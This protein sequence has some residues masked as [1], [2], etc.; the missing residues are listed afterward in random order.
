MGPLMPVGIVPVM[1][2]PDDRAGG[3]RLHRELQTV[4]G[5]ASNV[6]RHA[7]RID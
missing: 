1:F 3:I 6:M 4:E 7:G 2:A 5:H